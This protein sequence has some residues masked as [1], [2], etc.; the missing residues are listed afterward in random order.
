MG[1]QEEL[2]NAGYR[3][4]TSGEESDV[5]IFN[6]CT[7]TERTDRRLLKMIRKIA[8]QP[9]ETLIIVAGCGAQN[10]HSEY[11]K[12]P[13]VRAIIGNRE[14]N[15]IAEFVRD[16]LKGDSRIIEISDLTRAPF[17]RLSISRFRDYTRAFVKIQEG[18]NRDCSYCIIPVVRGPSRSQKPELVIKEIQNLADRHYREVVLTGIDLGVYG[19]DLKPATTLVSLLSAIETIHGIARIRLSSIE[20]MEFGLPLIKKLTDS[21]KICRHFHIPLQ[22]A[23]NRI[24]TLMSR[25]YDRE[26]YATIIQTLKSLS[27]DTCIGADVI[28]G[29]PGE[30]NAEFEDGYRF[31]ERL[32]VDYLHVFSYSDRIGRPASRFPD[33]LSPDTKKARCHALRELSFR[34]SVNFRKQMIGKEL[35]VIVLG[36]TDK[37][38]GLP[39]GL[40]DNYIKILLH[41]CHLMRGEIRKVIPE[42]VEGLTC[43]GRV[44]D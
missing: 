44:A 40:S 41:G 8:K 3:I 20:P 11:L 12:I 1:M 27:P 18:C 24:L 37:K 5:V 32:P 42:R 39:Q 36:V 13:A 29:F 21:N 26:D 30:T 38:T 2:E 10:S 31:I 23:N 4:V 17:E 19:L 35:S 34:K 7:V 16:V 6:T 22:S 25:S 28:T 33:K 15:R 9:S 43:Y 14:K